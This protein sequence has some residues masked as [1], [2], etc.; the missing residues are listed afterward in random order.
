MH[1]ETPVVCLGLIWVE[2]CR[3]ALPHIQTASDGALSLGDGRR[4]W[5]HYSRLADASTNEENAELVAL[6]LELEWIERP[7]YEKKYPF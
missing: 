6:F 1:F 5:A 7:T 3:P 2:V 4:W